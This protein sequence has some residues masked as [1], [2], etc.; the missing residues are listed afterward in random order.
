MNKEEK[1]GIILQFL[2]NSCIYFYIINRL[3]FLNK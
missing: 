2:E 1:P 3:L